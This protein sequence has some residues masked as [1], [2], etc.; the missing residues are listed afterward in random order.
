[1]NR[2]NVF[3]SKGKHNHGDEND[4]FA[5]DDVLVCIVDQI[6]TNATIVDDN[7]VDRFAQVDGNRFGRST[8]SDATILNAIAITIVV[9]R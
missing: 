8:R 7:V 5:D 2:N 6:A 3:H 4:Q 9:H 1:M